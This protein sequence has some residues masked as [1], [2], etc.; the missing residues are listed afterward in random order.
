MARL[1]GQKEEINPDTVKNFFDKRAQ[2]DVE[3][4]MTITSFNEN[5]TLKKRQEEEINLISKKIDF[6]GKK[7]L[8][9]G[10]GVGRWAEFFHDKCSEY[11]G[12]DY[13]ENL[14]EIAEKQFNFSNCYF[15]IL[16]ATEID[17]KNLPITGPYDIIFMTGLIMY[18]NDKD[19]NIMIEKINKIKHKNSIIYI[20]ESTSVLDTRLT[21]KD[22]YSQELESDYNVIYR[23]KEELLEF[24]ENIENIDSIET[25]LIHTEL[26]DF[27]ETSF[28]YFILK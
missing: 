3:N 19:I 10:C 11:V 13:S 1:Y 4:L 27:E 28:R 8:E 18:L 14:I 24:F 2:K 5:D 7:L 9:I 17:E 22:F 15:K 21:L 20:R 16:S 23:T 25:S 6:Y 12:I 26:N